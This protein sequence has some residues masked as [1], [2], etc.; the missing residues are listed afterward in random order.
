MRRDGR[1]DTVLGQ[2]GLTPKLRNER[3]QQFLFLDNGGPLFLSG[4]KRQLILRNRALRSLNLLLRTCELFLPLSFQKI[5]D[6]FLFGDSGLVGLLLQPLSVF[7]F[8]R[9]LRLQSRLRRGLLLL[10]PLLLLLS[11]LSGSQIRL[12]LG[13]IFVYEFLV[14]LLLLLQVSGQCPL[15]F[16]FTFLFDL[17][18]ELLAKSGEL[19]LKVLLS[20]LLSF[21]LKFFLP[22][23][24]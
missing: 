19:F 9:L 3:F 16:S 7:F 20:L 1:S 24:F 11:D 8:F 17:L 23:F 15:K 10:P 6:S 14:L 12:L 13:C 2:A 18:F 4:F 21:L 5:V 22:L